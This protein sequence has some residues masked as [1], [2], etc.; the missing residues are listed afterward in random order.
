[1]RSDPATSFGT[2]SDMEAL[3]ALQENFLSLSYD[4]S[5][6]VTRGRSGHRPPPGGLVILPVE[7]FAVEVLMEGRTQVVK[8]V[9]TL[10]F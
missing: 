9:N 1:M 5:P 6:D 10:S 3:L 8:L 2:I 4:L 7:L